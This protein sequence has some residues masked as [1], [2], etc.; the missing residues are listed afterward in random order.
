LVSF[1]LTGLSFSKNPKN[2][3]ALQLY[4]L[5]RDH[6]TMSFTLKD[7]EKCFFSMDEQSARNKALTKIALG[8]AANSLKRGKQQ[9]MGWSKGN[10]R[11]KQQ[12]KNTSNAN[13]TTTSSGKSII[14]Y[15]CGEPGHI[16]PNCPNPKQNILNDNTI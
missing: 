12:N 7:V 13:A 2:Y 3:T 9:S 8:H 5:E 11:N 15:N 14:C 6:G 4:R 1:A 16:S 10:H